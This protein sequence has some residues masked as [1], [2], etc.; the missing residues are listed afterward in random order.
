MHQGCEHLPGE[1]KGA[2]IANP[3]PMHGSPLAL[4]RKLDISRHCREVAQLAQLHYTI[5]VKGAGRPKYSRVVPAQLCRRVHSLDLVLPHLPA[6]GRASGLTQGS[7]GV[8][9]RHDRRT[10]EASI[11]LLD[12][13]VAHIAQHDGKIDPGDSLQNGDLV[14]AGQLAAVDGRGDDG[15]HARREIVAREETA[16][17]NSPV[18]A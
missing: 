9:S 17:A 16:R 13:S 15:V 6:S 14:C 11:C 3:W 7:H 2:P 10:E 12:L 4:L 5:F 8:A 18:Q 1:E